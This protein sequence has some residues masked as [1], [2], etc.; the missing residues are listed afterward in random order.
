VAVVVLQQ[1]IIIP[2]FRMPGLAK[3]VAATGQPAA[4][5]QYSGQYPEHIHSLCHVM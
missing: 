2:E 4:N 3:P 1:V 5:Q